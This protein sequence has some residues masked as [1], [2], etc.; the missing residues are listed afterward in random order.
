[1]TPSMTPSLLNGQTILVVDDSPENID[2]LSDVLR[3][4]Y[5]IRVATHG[6]KALKIVYSDNPPDLILLDIMMPDISGLEL[7]RRL[8]A[9]P[10]RCSIPVIFVTA[11]ASSEDEQCGLETG[12]VDYITKPISPPIVLARVRTH[13]ALYDQTRELERMVQQRTHELNATRQEII[14]RLSCAAEYRDYETGHH[15]LRVAHYSR[16]LAQAHGLGER[17]VETIFTTAPMHDVGKIGISDQLLRKPGALTPTEWAIMRTHCRIGASIIGNHDDELLCNARIVAL[18]HHERWDGTGY[19]NGLKGEEIPISGRVVAIADVF[20]ALL[21]ERPYKP[22]FTL[23]EALTYMEHGDGT[24]F[25]P[26][27]MAT[28]RRCLPEL[29]EITH[30]YSDKTSSL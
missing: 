12:A 22:A 30:K 6:D 19:P 15:V 25:D 23:E 11:M 9:N 10:D 27:L 7:C 2:I 17:M 21:S 18:T 3:P 4:Y 24:H 13:L 20:D 8:K 26:A 5:R 28:F 29:L 14:H 16:I 1:M